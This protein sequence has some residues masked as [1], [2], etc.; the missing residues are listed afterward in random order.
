MREFLQ[1]AP[2]LTPIQP[3]SPDYPNQPEADLLDEGSILL[4]YE[5]DLSS[6]D[7]SLVDTGKMSFQGSSVGQIEDGRGEPLKKWICQELDEPE[8][9]TWLRLF[10]NQ[11]NELRLALHDIKKLLVSWKIN[12]QGGENGLQSCQ[13]QVI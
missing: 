5:S 10:E 7:K 11:R 2:T 12:F 8:Q 1:K 6:D 13:A 9:V 3:E 4:S